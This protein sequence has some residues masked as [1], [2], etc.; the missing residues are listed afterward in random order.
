M[1][2]SE[3]VEAALARIRDDDRELNCFTA[4]YEER[5]RREAAEVD[6]SGLQGPLAGMPYAV[7]NLFDVEGFPT[8]A[9]SKINAELPPAKRDAFAVRKLRE[10]GAVLIGSL[11]M[12]EYAYGFTTENSHYGPTRNPHDP[13][14]IAGGSSGGSGAA[15]AAGLVPLALGS[16]TNGS[17]RVPASLCGVF[18]LKPTFGRLSR[19]GVFPL[20]A[21]FDHIGP[22]ARTV[23]DLAACYDA[24]QGYDEEDPACAQRALQPVL[25]ALDSGIEDLRI[26]V[27]AGGPYDNLAPEARTAVEDVARSLSATELVEIPEPVRARAATVLITSAESSSL[28]LPN[29]RTR[30]RDFDPLTRDRL[31]A[32]ALLPAH[33]VLQAQR[34]R[35]WYGQATV[36]LFEKADVLIAAATPF[37]ATPIG[38]DTIEI[39]GKKHPVRATLGLLT[40][41]FSFAGVPVLTVPV[42]KRGKMPIGVQIICAPWRETLAFRVAAHLE[43]EGFSCG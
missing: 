24:L 6:R 13:N 27:A 11:N 22:F 37:S 2:A 41:P 36:R 8:L 23:R 33:W 12:D 5:A 30:P 4:V 15:V 39:S 21:S 3:R 38:E 10:A 18:A 42:A 9:G 14:R 17:I 19:Q 35:Q 32:G 40:A 28:H 20:A 34:F 16:D 26:A 1:N 7:K 31:L 29:L 43:K 25:P